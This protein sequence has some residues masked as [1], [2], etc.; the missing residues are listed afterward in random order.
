M[1][2]IREVREFQNERFVEY[3]TIR[4]DLPY[5]LIPSNVREE[6]S[7]C[8]DEEIVKGLYVTP[9][10]RITW[11]TLYL[12]STELAERLLEHLH[13]IFKKRNY[14]KNYTLRIEIDITSEKVT[15]TKGKLKHS[16]QVR[17]VLS[18]VANKN[19]SL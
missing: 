2:K 8:G 9:T 15:A 1:N 5:K 11:K 13:V 19:T 6:D 7:T 18:K 4:V 16:A 12:N 14:T 10:G 17:E 3:A